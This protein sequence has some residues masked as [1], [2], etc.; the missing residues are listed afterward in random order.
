M[1]M[2][3]FFIRIHCHSFK[4]A[5]LLFFQ[6][7]SNM[8][9]NSNCSPHLLKV[10]VCSQQFKSKINCIL[11]EAQKLR[12]VPINF[13]QDMGRDFA[14]FLVSKTPSWPCIRRISTQRMICTSIARI[15]LL[16]L[17]LIL[18]SVKGSCFPFSTTK[19]KLVTQLTKDIQATA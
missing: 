2:L 8:Q 11:R 7:K 19:S 17:L 9:R 14:I 12:V 5:D 16:Q 6:W 13:S 4:R 18:G 1:V 10:W 3:W 15:D